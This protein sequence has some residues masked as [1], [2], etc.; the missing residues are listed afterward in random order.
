M[1]DT[2]DVY[3]TRGKTS[4]GPGE[5]FSENPL[6]AGRIETTTT[7]SGTRLLDDGAQL[8][9]AIQSGDWVSGTLAGI[10]GAADLVAAAIDPI[11]AAIAAGVGWILDHL[12]PLKTW[13]NELTG[14]AGSVAGAAAT[15]D[16]I[17]RFL[18]SSA[19]DASQILQ[20]YFSDQLSQAMDAFRTLQSE[21]AQHLSMA[22]G[23]ASAISTGLTIA[24]TLVQ[25]VHDLVRDAIGDIVGKFASSAIA[26]VCTLGIATPWVV[27]N[28]TATVSKWAARLS[29]EVKSLIRS[30]D[31]LSG[32][33]RRVEDL[34]GRLKGA[35]SKVASFK[36]S[37]EDAASSLGSQT[38]KTI[39]KDLDKLGNHAATA[40]QFGRDVKTIGGQWLRP[41]FSDDI[42]RQMP[43]STELM[44]DILQSPKSKAL[45]NELGVEPWDM[46]TFHAKKQLGVDSPNLPTEDKQILHSLREQLGGIQ[47][48]EIVS[49]IHLNQRPPDTYGDI[50]GYFAPTRETVDMTPSEKF[51]AVRG[52][53]VLDP[54]SPDGPVYNRYDADKP[55]YETRVLADE[56]FVEGT[57]TPYSTD[58]VDEAGASIP[59]GEGIGETRFQQNRGV[60]GPFTGHGFTSSRDGKVIPE[61][62]YEGPNGN[63]RYQ[64]TYNLDTGRRVSIVVENPLPWEKGSVI[65]IPTLR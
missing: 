22:S 57:K 21:Y 51:E 7:F 14:D 9:Q 33:V 28:L 65:R 10:S 35:F 29:T 20:S 8:T 46:D 48:G 4:H 59:P 36:K 6:V 61:H 3:G 64:E 11:G 50:R 52:D 49:K 13:M 55:M 40:K 37:L 47:D 63:V 54:D 43:S 16:N 24:S 18:Q 31:E 25:V 34:L 38:G 42:A 1:S 26:E 39:R 44:P 5:S 56:S 30:F 15:W 12:E 41:Q 23:L 27:A 58:M 17:S 32:L 19:E 60:E 2:I 62:Y 53:Y 45:F